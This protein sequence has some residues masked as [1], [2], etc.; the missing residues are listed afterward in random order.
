MI[1]ELLAN[2]TR[3][4]FLQNFTTRSA[5]VIWNT[6]AAGP[7]FIEFGTNIETAVR[8]GLPKIA[9]NH[10]A[11]LTN[12]LPGT[13]YVYRAGLLRNGEEFTSDWSTLRTF[14]E[15]GGLDFE[16][17]G[18]SGW[19]SVAQF[20]IARE[21][22]QSSADLIVHVGDL[23]YFGFTRYVA[24]SRF[25]S[26]YAE[27]MQHV[28]L[29]VAFGNHEM[30]LDRT[31]VLDALYLPTNNVT[32]TEHF[33]SFEDGDAHFAIL[34]TDLQSGADYGPGS[35]QY[36]WLENDLASTSKPW[37]FLFFHQVWRSSSLHDYDDY[38]SD[39][40]IDTEELE[41]GPATLARKYGVQIIFNGHDHG[42]QRFVP[43]GGP[44]SFI[45]GGGGA[46]LYPLASPHPEMT[47]F[48][49]RH[50]FLQVSLRGEEATVNAVGEDGRIFD[51][52]T[53]RRTLPERKPLEAAWHTVDIPAAPANDG[54]GNLMGQTFNFSGSAIA[55]L[56]GSFS[57]AGRLHVNNDGT[58]LYI[59]FDEVMLRAGDELF[60]FI[61]SPNLAG[62]TNLQNTGNGVL[63]PSGE[64][65]DALDFLSNLSFTNFAPAI[66]LVL[67]DEFADEP[68]RT[69]SRAGVPTAPGQG[70]F[71][72]TNGLPAVPGQ[73]LTQFNLSPQTEPILYEQNADNIEISLPLAA[74]GIAP[75][76]QVKIGAIVGHTLINTNALDSHYQARELD[77]GGIGYEIFQANERT[78]LE[79]IEVR[80][81]DST[82]HFSASINRLAAG[83]LEISWDAAPGRKYSLEVSDSIAGPFTLL[84][85]TDFPRTATSVQ[86]SYSINA[87]AAPAVSRF[88]RI[89]LMP[90]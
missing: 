70:A 19:A 47:H 58:N 72:L 28:P 29:Y 11:T 77:S 45:S 76:A 71:Y 54:D 40:T 43:G 48:W 36:Q 14:S 27:Q 85:Q 80:L 87:V 60:A 15:S 2:F 86:E 67:G 66:G 22:R 18:D 6:S 8:M 84:N 49:S 31:A 89:A 10:V 62:A 17:V 20:D 63:D 7:G 39:Q 50:N 38:D 23:A 51:S 1:P 16:V 61:E 74:L 21:M 3:G 44:I 79:G 81:A 37:K 24:D 26:V 35:P 69:F 78:Y 42:Y 13:V 41:R 4:P 46:V 25:F 57:G 56:P 9:T 55:S 12:L 34:W 33:Y 73:R 88:Y 5:R 32:G 65:A 83:V 52:L 82:E 64:G 59:G 90:Q 68:S 75:G 53:I 30:Y